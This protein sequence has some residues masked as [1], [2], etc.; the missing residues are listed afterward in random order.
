MKVNRS[1]KDLK[2]RFCAF[3]NPLVFWGWKYWGRWWLHCNHTPGCRTWLKCRR[4]WKQD[5]SKLKNRIVVK[6]YLKGNSMSVIWT[7]PFFPHAASTLS[8]KYQS[9]TMFWF[10]A[11]HQ[12]LSCNL[13]SISSLGVNVAF[14]MSTLNGRSPSENRS[15]RI[16]QINN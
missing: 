11:A 8:E 3:F 2:S 12:L 9:L 14:V 16:D 7:S 13:V 6:N 5:R 4:S 15:F 1:V 10:E